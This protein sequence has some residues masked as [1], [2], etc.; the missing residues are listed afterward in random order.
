M[1]DRAAVESVRSE[2]EMVLETF[3]CISAFVHSSLDPHHCV[4]V[5]FL[6]FPSCSPLQ[7]SLEG[8]IWSMSLFV[9]AGILPFLNCSLFL[10]TSTEIFL[11]IEKIQLHL[12]GLQKSC[13]CLSSNT[14]ISP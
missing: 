1:S 14:Y 10:S 9:Q 11:K 5:T 6:M 8:D 7:M 2:L 3:H 12:T 13:I 4:P